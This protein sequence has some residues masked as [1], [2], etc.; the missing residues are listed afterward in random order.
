MRSLRVVQMGLVLAATLATSMARAAVQQ[1]I[2]TVN[3]GELVRL[4]G[5]VSPRLSV[6]TTLGEVAPDKQLTSM[7]LSFSMTDA[8]QTALTTLLGQLQDP[9]SPKY[10][11]WLTP[12]QFRTQFGL[13]DADV[14]QVK[15]W[16][17]SQGL[18]VT[19]VARGGQFLRF[20]GTAA[21]VEAAFQTRLERVSLHGEEHFANATAPSLPAAIAAVTTGV[22]G[23]DDF[24][25]KPHVIQREIQGKANAMHPEYTSPASGN[26]YLAPGDL[27]TM[28]D[29][30]TLASSLNGSL[31]SAPKIAVVGQSDV[32]LTNIAN[33]RS[34]SGLSANIPTVQLYG[35]DPGTPSGTDVTESTLDLEWAGAMSPA[36]SIVF[37]NS[38]NVI[39]GSLTEAIDNNLAPIIAMSYGDCE[40]DLQSSNLAHYNVLLAQGAAQ[41]IT[42]VA[43]SGDSG[44]SDCDYNVAIAK[45]GYGVDFPGSSPYV[46]SVGG[47]ELNE[48]T[49]SYW[50]TSNGAYQGSA[51]S[52]IPEV[53]W[54]DDSYGSLAASGGGASSYFVKPSWQQGTGVPSDGARDVPDVALPASA[55]HD[56]YLICTTGYCSNGYFSSGGFLSVVGGTSVSAPVFAG[57]LALVEQK[58]GGAPMGVVNGKIY[59]LAG[60]TYNGNVFHDIVSGN[61]NSPCTTGT[62]N[63]AS[64]VAFGYTATAGYDQTTGWGS[65][66]A[67]NLATY[68]SQV[69]GYTSTPTGATPTYVNLTGSASSIQAG[70]AVTFNVTVASAVTS[71]T[72]VPTGTVQFVIDGTTTGSPVSL[73]AAAATYSLAT[74]SLAAGSHRIQAM[75]SGDG[76]YLGSSASWTLTVATATSTDFT[77]SPATATLSASSGASSSPLTLTVTSVNGF[78]GNVTFSISASNTSASVLP[79]LSVTSVAVTSGGSASTTLT[80]LA[81]KP[82]SAKSSLVTMGW[83]GLGGV[84]L[85]SLLLLCMPKRRKMSSLLVLVAGVAVVSMSG[86]SNTANTPSTP[87]QTNATA[88]TYT[89]TVFATGSVNNTSVTHSS[90][91][92]FTVK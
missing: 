65:V 62:T 21:Q 68:W 91:V 37:V 46:T 28:Y 56:P 45:Q 8:Q 76:T 61:N 26:H 57:M 89:Y 53:V 43:S 6:A 15:A 85:G 40:A 83:T 41:G 87:A 69:A 24:R 29:V 48:G 22:H 39:D 17:Q 58:T 42:I 54:N 88:G 92:T 25:P 51:K 75:Y 20:S 59:A 9:A 13:A 82:S 60:S 67:A 44:A 55:D 66:D 31:V 72:A 12:E 71:V 34:A 73:S 50:N 70:A 7:T 90:V 84:T 16:L 49:G 38:T 3:D 74:A 4:A 64:G 86:C 33:F 19:E 81:F 1:R 79:V 78:S 2:A 36:S 11:Q 10:H 35:A 5:N 80:L 77:L 14:A 63:C 47:T 32:S 18:T 23:L 52:Y 30:S 27:Y